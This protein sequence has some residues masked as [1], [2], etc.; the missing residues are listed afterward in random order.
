MDKGVARTI[1]I[2]STEPWGKMLLSKMHFALELVRNGNRVFFVNPTRP[3]AGRKLAVTGEAMEGGRLT[4]IHTKAV[5]G[6]LF[7]RHKVFFLYR[8]LN[9]RYISAIKAIAGSAIDEVWSFNANQYVDL[10]PFGAKKSIV[11]LY[12]LYRGDHIFRA[13]E[14]ADA[15]ISVSQ[16]ILDHY[17]DTPPPKLFIQHGLGAHFADR[18]RQR[19]RTED[20]GTGGDLAGDG[21]R[22][23]KVGYTGNLLRV[24]MNTVVATEIIGKHPEIEFHF[25]GPH[26]MKDNNVNDIGYSAPPELLDFIGFLQRQENVFLHGVVAQQELAARL[27]EMDA[28]L[29]MYSPKQEL[30]GASNAH[31]LLEYISTGRVVIATHVSS[32]ADT[33]LLVMCDSR[34]EERLPEIFDQTIKNLSFHN[35][36]ERQIK[37]IG[38]ALDNT[39]S[40]Q[41]ERVQRFIT[42]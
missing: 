37:R 3:L 16:V 32:Y 8:R 40:R 14:K 27:F 23:V 24:G 41:V 11:L 2:L 36:R 18:S 19:L 12:D 25:W 13:V 20:F 29:F 42:G 7:L 39:Y 38:F 34:E 31:K 35:A 30:N 17:K 26:S 22:K 5:K 15:L 21:R 9:R 28:F 33:D 6:A 4:I 1:V 10:R